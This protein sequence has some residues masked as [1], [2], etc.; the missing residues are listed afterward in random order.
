MSMLKFFKPLEKP[1]VAPSTNKALLDPE[2]LLTNVLLPSAINMVNNEVL[3][4]YVPKTDPSP[5][6]SIS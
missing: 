2:G 4:V 5:I 3:K 6:E 1:L